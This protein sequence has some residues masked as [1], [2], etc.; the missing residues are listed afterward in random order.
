MRKAI[1][2]ILTVWILVNVGLFSLII[3]SPGIEVQVSATTIIVDGDGTPGVDCNYTTIQEGIDATNPGDTVFVK[4]GTYFENVVVN[5]TINLTGEDKDTT[6]IDSGGWEIVVLISADWVN[7]SGFTVT[8]SGGFWGDMGMKLSNVQNCRIVN[9]NVSNNRHGIFLSSSSSNTITNNTASSNSFEGIGLVTSISNT[10]FN[11]EM[12]DNGISIEGDMVEHWNTHTIDTTNTVNGKPVYY[13]K[14]QTGGTVPLGAGQVI[15]ANST[16]VIVENQN[17]SDGSIGIEFGFS[18]RNT[19]T[20]NTAS[21]NMWGIRLYSSSSNTIASN[22]ASSNNVDGIYLYYSHGNTMANNNASSN[23]Y[24]GIYLLTS[25]SNTI[26]NNN[27]SNNNLGILIRDLSDSNTITNNTASLNKAYAIVLDDSS[28]N[29]ITNNNASNNSGGIGLG[30]YSNSNNITNNTA[31]NN[32]MG[33]YIRDLSDSNNITNNTVSLNSNYGISLYWA[34]SNTIANNTVSSNKEYGIR[35]SLSNSNK[36]FHNNILGNTNQAYD[37]TNNGNQW[38]NGYPFGGNYWSDYTGIDHNSTANQD[39]PPPDGIGD[40]PYIIDSDS[41][42]NYPLMNPIGNLTYLYEGWNLISIPY[43]QPDT[44]LGSVLSTISGSYNAVQ[45]YNVSDTSNMWKH[46]QTSK[47]SYLNDL[48]HINQN[49][50]FWIRITESGGVL[51]AYPGTQPTSNQSIPLH[52]GWNMVGYPS[53]TNRD[54][55]AALNNLTFGVEVDAVWTFDAATQT[56]EEISVGDY[57][58]VG[59]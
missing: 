2:S 35:L 40:T 46:Y 11:N 54:R 44:N 15:L 23:G 53:L 22:T 36:I 14:N 24:H 1:I 45:W 52:P 57:F 34:N 19:I 42:D 25:S 28:S 17:V 10:I 41:Q 43:I 6:I 32:N 51:F 27:A 39:V 33:I 55:T 30:S 49:M 29:N 12:V 37:D 20:N 38:D 59:I 4:N 13:W 56:W 5:K 48:I 21:S 50:A 9:N 18:S 3:L 7:V 16:K 8:N 58:E 31:S 47:P 26:A